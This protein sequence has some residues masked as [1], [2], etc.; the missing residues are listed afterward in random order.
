M[1]DLSAAELSATMEDYLEA[2][3]ALEQSQQVA[4]VR[5]IA[6]HLQVKMPSVSGALKALKARDLVNHEA[7]GYVT[8]TPQG[9]RLALQVYRRHQVMVGFMQRIMR[10]PSEQAEPEACR[11]EHAL[12]A[13]VL[14]RLLALTEFMQTA[15]QVEQAWLQYLEEY[16]TTEDACE[17]PVEQDVNLPGPEI[18]TMDRVEPGTVARIVRVCGRG[19]VRRRL[20]DMGLRSGVLV[21]IVR[22]APL[23]DPIEIK[24]M[25]YH[26][27]LRREEAANLQVEVVEAASVHND[28]GAAGKGHE[29]RGRNGRHHRGRGIAPDDC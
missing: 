19:P 4:R 14:N 21:R 28:N 1:P 17:L 6:Q 24:V 8:L 10:I 16:E 18:V 22:F 25:D 12:S 20:L 2:I 29:G 9:R 7:Y 13:E 23:G 3:Y 11:L 26:L 15:P 27:S 5:D